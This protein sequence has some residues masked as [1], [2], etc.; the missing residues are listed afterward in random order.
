[1]RISRN[2]LISLCLAPYT[3]AFAITPQG[4]SL[5]NV[6]SRNIQKLHRTYVTKEASVKRTSGKSKM[7]MFFSS[8]FGSLTPACIDYTTLDF[9]GPECAKY[10]Q[11]DNIV[12]KS[13]RYPHLSA[14]TFAGGCFWGLELAYQRILGVSYTAVGYTHGNDD[15]PTYGQVCSGATGHT[16]AVIV[17]YDPKTCDYNTL[18]DV[19]FSRIDPTQVNG[20]G[21]DRGTQYRTGVYFHTSEQEK[22]AIARFESEKGKYQRQIASELKAARPFWPAE[23]YHQQYL[24]KGGQNAK[25]N[26]TERI[27][28]YG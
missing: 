12:V 17:Y 13:D 25:K 27:R 20:Q 24:E 15:N 26:A 6:S 10:A 5:A 11:E 14:A 28:C 9:P 16:E 23:K 21:N 18:L 1:M 22:K 2:T 4:R 7:G 19:F 8:L 3:S